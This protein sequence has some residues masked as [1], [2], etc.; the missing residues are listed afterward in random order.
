MYRGHLDKL[1]DNLLLGAVNAY[2]DGKV[3][4]GKNT[5]NS[6][7]E[8][9]AHIARDYK[10]K[11]LKWIIIGD[12][13]YGE[14]SSREHAAMTPRYLGMCS[15]YC[16]KFCKNSRNQPQETRNISINIY[17]SIRL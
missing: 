13:N 14:G 1:S 2:Q 5:L 6:K 16:Q 7:I 15:S 8:S 11:G 9:F 4:L 10:E 17:R 12:K 3:G